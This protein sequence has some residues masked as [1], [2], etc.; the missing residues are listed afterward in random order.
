MFNKPLLIHVK[1]GL[2]QALPGLAPY[3]ASKAGLS[4]FLDALRVELRKYGVD[5]V[6]F[7]PGS[8]VMTSNIVGAHAQQSDLQRRAMSA[9]QWRF[10]GEYFERYHGFLSFLR[11]PPEPRS[12][13][14]ANGERVMQMLEATLL[15]KRPRAVYKLEPNWRYCVYH[16]FF[17]W[18]PMPVRDYLIEKFMS[19][20]VYIP[21]N[22]LTETK[23]S[24]GV[25]FKNST[26]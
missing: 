26:E 18:T 4:N 16:W 1:L 10:Y 22:K 15:E 23:L 8:F 24:N 9:D 25:E 11:G 20:P 2:H 13:D 17:G 14:D 7:I 21:G 3:A 12:W 6:N 19:M 5:V